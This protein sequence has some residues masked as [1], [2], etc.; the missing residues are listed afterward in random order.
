MVSTPPLESV[1]GADSL[2]DALADPGASVA[3]IADP[4]AGREAALDRAERALDGGDRTR[5]EPEGGPPSVGEEPLVVDDCHHLYARRVGGFDRID[6]FLDRV[7]ASSTQV[8]TSWNR[9][10]WQYLDATRDV[11][12]PFHHVLSVPAM[13][14]DRIADAIRA[15]NEP[16]PTF[17]SPPSGHDSMFTAVTYEIPLPRRGP[18]SVEIPVVDID[19]VSAWL[20]ARDVPEPDAIVFERLERLSGGNLG[21]ASAIWEQCVSGEAVV[22]DDLYRPVD[23]SFD[24]GD[25]ATEVLGVAV[26]K[27]AVTRDEL[28]AVVP[29]VRLD[30]TLHSL[31]DHGFLTVDDVVRLR[32]GG[33]PSALESL[34]RRR[35][36]W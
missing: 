13:A 10:S 26:A 31:A 18:L 2:N 3:V 4:F 21:V 12:D 24:P 17:E 14:S 28:A 5:V 35:W 1:T 15:R 20:G 27:E 11:A 6:A 34:K 23:R 32:P 22:P 36:Q 9:Y 19:Y 8:V 16:L 29:D 30:R 7:A 33:L 25:G